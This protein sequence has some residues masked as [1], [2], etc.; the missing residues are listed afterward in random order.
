MVFTPTLINY[1]DRPAQVRSATIVVAAHDATDRERRN[2]DLVCR[3][4]DDQ[5]VIQEAI[6]YLS[7]T[8]GIVQLT[9]GDF[10]ISG[11]IDPGDYVWTRGMGRATLLDMALLS[12]DVGF[13]AGADG[14]AARTGFKIS[15]LRVDGNF[16]GTDNNSDTSLF[17]FH[18]CT[19]IE[20]DN[21]EANR[22]QSTAFYVLGP[23]TSGIRIHNFRGT[24]SSR[25]LIEIAEGTNIEINHVVSIE[26]NV[27]NKGPSINL[28][29]GASRTISNARLNN[30]YVKS[31]T[32]ANTG[33]SID[34]DALSGVVLTNFTIEGLAIHQLRI[35]GTSLVRVSNGVIT[36]GTNSVTLDADNRAINRLSISDLTLYTPVSAGIACNFS[37]TSAKIHVRNIDIYGESFTSL[38]VVVAAAPD[39]D[40]TSF[41]LDDTHIYNVVSEGVRDATAK[42][43][44]HNVTVV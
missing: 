27:T 26:D 29:G 14:I 23:S 9:T 44:Q 21:V 32:G 4:V 38:G 39:D 42:I 17:Q 25:G 31:P 8:G 12:T 15:D 30:I 37:L 5:T 24:G 34:G 7:G 19:D 40:V 2:A 16:A 22:S 18:D 3:G 41:Y 35:V 6:D 10:E 36:G 1:T 20:I 43:T 11:F 13:H 28:E 33:I